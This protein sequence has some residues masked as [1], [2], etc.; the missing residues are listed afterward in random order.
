METLSRLPFLKDYQTTTVKQQIYIPAP[1]ASA[2]LG[3]CHFTF[4]YGLKID[5]PHRDNLWSLTPFVLLTALSDNPFL[6]LVPLPSHLTPVAP[7]RGL[8]G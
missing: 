7:L 8:S 6:F 1:F 4:Q 2:F 3:K 5:S